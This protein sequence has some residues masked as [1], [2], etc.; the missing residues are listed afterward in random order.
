MAT[1][2]RALRAQYRAGGNEQTYDLDP[3]L[4]ATR[5]LP[6]IRG[7]IYVGTLPRPVRVHSAALPDIGSQQSSAP[8]RAVV[9]NGYAGSRMARDPLGGRSLSHH[10]EEAC[11]V[12]LS[13]LIA[14]ISTVRG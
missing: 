12:K 13:I 3:V 10:P 1:R 11:D 6:G 4:H 5:I 7:P 8:V 14:S 2:C 9:A